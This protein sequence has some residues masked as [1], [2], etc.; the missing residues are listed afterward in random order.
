MTDFFKWV[1][2]LLASANLIIPMAYVL[3]T[4]VAFLV[5][6]FVLIKLTSWIRKDTPHSKDAISESL[7]S[8]KTMTGE[9]LTKHERSERDILEIRVQLESLQN[10][11]EEIKSMV[12]DSSSDFTNHLVPIRVIL[13]GLNSTL[14]D[15][16]DKDGVNT[17]SIRHLS[18]ELG[19]LTGLIQG[20][21]NTTSRRR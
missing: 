7:T 1:T 4:A 11:I 6:G 19:T 9:V 10:S 17:D 14:R 13:E 21:Y 5:V 15:Y 20:L 8:L 18:M 16:K 3:G 2:G 12:G